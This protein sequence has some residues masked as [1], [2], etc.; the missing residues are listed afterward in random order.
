MN[1]LKLLSAGLIA[2]TMLAAP[3]MAREH[4]ATSR[5][6]AANADANLAPGTRYVDG[7]LCY[8]APRVGAFATA[9]WDNENVPCY[10]AP[11]PGSVY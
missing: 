3:A 9:P 4:Y 5:S 2:A 1:K 6:F 7:R 8:P 11:Y 10:P